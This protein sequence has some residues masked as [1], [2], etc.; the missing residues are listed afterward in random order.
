MKETSKKRRTRKRKSR[1]GR[2]EEKKPA[3]VREVYDY[4]AIACEDAE[5]CLARADSLISDFSVRR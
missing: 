5:E 3:E 4:E 1:K 2:A